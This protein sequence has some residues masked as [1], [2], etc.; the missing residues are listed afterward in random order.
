[1]SDKI[2]ATEIV[3]ELKKAAR[4]YEVFKQAA[5]AAEILASFEKENNALIKQREA[6]SKECLELDAACNNAVE[7]ATK[8]EQDRIR[9]V[10]EAS[11]VIAKAE[12]NALSIINEAKQKAIDMEATAVAQLTNSK[13]YLEELKEEIKTLENRKSAAEKAAKKAESTVQKIK[14]EAI[15]ALS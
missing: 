1:M 2:K 12:S 6:L 7:E 10:N 5:K 11:N 15:A 4:M 3:G 8:A 14:N 9:A 13:N